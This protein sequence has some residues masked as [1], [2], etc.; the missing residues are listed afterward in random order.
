MWNFQMK[1]GLR[2]WRPGGAPLVVGWETVGGWI[3][4]TKVDNGISPNS[5]FVVVATQSFTV[6]S[7]TKGIIHPH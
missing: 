4:G 2:R 7:A 5:H 1:E 6:S 3:V